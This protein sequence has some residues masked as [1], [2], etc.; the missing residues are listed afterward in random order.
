MN[1]LNSI[2]MKKLFL[3]MAAVAMLSGCKSDDLG[4]DTIDNDD[5]NTHVSAGNI[6]S[7]GTAINRFLESLNADLDDSAKMEK[8]RTWLEAHSSV[9]GADIHCVSCIYT[10]PAQSEL[11]ISFKVN[12]NIRTLVMDIS[13]ANPPVFRGYHEPPETNQ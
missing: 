9:A 1:P 11:I 13:M 6:S 5:F 12:G 7:T 10:L 3:L 8:L 4:D 2:P